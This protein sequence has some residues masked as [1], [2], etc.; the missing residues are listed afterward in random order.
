MGSN[1][2][3]NTDATDC[4]GVLGNVKMA[5]LYFGGHC[6]YVAKGVRGEQIGD[7]PNRRAVGGIELPECFWVNSK[8]TDE[9]GST[10]DTSKRADIQ[11]RT[12]VVRVLAIGPMVGKRCSKQHAKKYDRPRNVPREVRVGDDVLCRDTT[13]GVQRSP[14]C[15]YEY[16]IEECIPVATIEKGS[17]DE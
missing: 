14:I 16:F 1:L 5:P 17:A 3:D 9:D 12:W 10:T 13:F 2:L 6:Y 8:F 4:A 11:D 15:D 7:D